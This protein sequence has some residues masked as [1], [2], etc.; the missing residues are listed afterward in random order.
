LVN[1]NFAP[2]ARQS[3]QIEEATR[4]V[5]LQ[6]FVA[7]ASSDS[8]LDEALASLVQRRVGAFVVAAD[9]YFDTRREKIVA[10]AA[11]AGLPAI[12]HFREFAVAGGLISYGPR[13]TEM[14][15]HAGAYVGR[16]LHGAKPADLPVLQPTKFE[17]VINLKTANTLNLTVP[18]S[19]QLL[20]D[21]VIE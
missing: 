17:L 9:P 20:A 14:Y 8:E 19:M 6:V 18:N 4:T 16:I 3:Q 10:F 13:I 1:P 5:G 12:Y 21:E 7:N 15:K 2:A 11:Q